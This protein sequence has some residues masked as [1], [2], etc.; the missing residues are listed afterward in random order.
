MMLE[1]ETLAAWKQWLR[2]PGSGEKIMV[3][4]GMAHHN[5]GV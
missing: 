3:C 1:P 4:M 2:N 5:L